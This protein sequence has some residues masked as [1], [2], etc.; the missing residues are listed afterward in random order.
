MLIT[1]AMES[2]SAEIKRNFAMK[3]FQQ[4]MITPGEMRSGFVYFQLPKVSDSP[5]RWR[6][7]VQALEP[8]DKT[9]LTYLYSFAWKRD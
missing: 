4:A 2:Q 5:E 9:E 6:L 7:E 1:M 8:K 3:E